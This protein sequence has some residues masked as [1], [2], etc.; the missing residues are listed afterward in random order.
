ME[1]PKL[2]KRMPKYLSLD[3]KK[4]LSVAENEDNRNYKYMMLLQHYF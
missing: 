2:E 4:L 1:T 3:S